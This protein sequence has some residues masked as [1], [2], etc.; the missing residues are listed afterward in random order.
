[1]LVEAQEPGSHPPPALDALGKEAEA[2]GSVIPVQGCCDGCI[3][4]SGD[5]SSSQV[6]PLSLLWEML[7]SPLPSIFASAISRRPLSLQNPTLSICANAAPPYGPSYL[8]HC[9]TKDKSFEKPPSRQGHPK[10]LVIYLQEGCVSGLHN[11]WVFS[12][13]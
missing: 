2:A 3:W 12:S 9:K 13:F 8:S 7:L 1:M 4:P 11:S 5:F 6:Q 10:R